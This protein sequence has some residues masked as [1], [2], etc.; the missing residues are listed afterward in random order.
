MSKDSR[1]PASAA[2]NLIGVSLLV[3]LPI[4]NG[5]ANALQLEEV[6]V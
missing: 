4:A 2:T 6:L 3:T 5:E 1:P